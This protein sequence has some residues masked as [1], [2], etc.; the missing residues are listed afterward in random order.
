MS[1]PSHRNA[2]SKN[3]A[4][5][6]TMPRKWHRRTRRRKRPDWQACFAWF[7]PSRAIV[8]QSSNTRYSFDGTTKIVRQ[9]G[10]ENARFTPWD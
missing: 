3:R 7:D 2:L 5:R 6:S 10:F 8:R 1:S 4:G 9:N